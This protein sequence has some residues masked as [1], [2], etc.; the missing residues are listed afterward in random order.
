MSCELSLSLLEQLAEFVV[1]GEFRERIIVL[2]D[3]DDLTGR[4]RN[5]YEDIDQ[6]GGTTSDRMAVL[7]LYPENS[8]GASKGI[9]GA[10]QVVLTH[11]RALQDI[12][13]MLLQGY[14]LTEI[15]KD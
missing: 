1:A 9:D 10:G 15:K 6:D 8:K 5:V 2:T 3:P 11:A 7:T 13:K 12:R 4:T 14:Q